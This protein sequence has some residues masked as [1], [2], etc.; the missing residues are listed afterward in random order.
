MRTWLISCMETQNRGNL[1][2][3]LKEKDTA[4]RYACW[5]SGKDTET[6]PES[7]SFSA[8]FHRHR[9][10]TCGESPDHGS[11]F[12]RS[13]PEAAI[14]SRRFSIQHSSAEGLVRTSDYVS[15]VD[16]GLGWALGG[17]WGPDA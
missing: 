1:I 16:L 7:R 13:R 3:E 15:C 14:R 17:P 2:R 6:R 11:R 12:H 9:V 4:A 5:R 8:T 10:E